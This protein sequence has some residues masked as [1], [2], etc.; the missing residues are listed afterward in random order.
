[1]AH[2]R[3]APHGNRRPPR[4]RPEAHVVQPP[5]IAAPI[6]EQA[7]IGTPVWI[8]TA[9]QRREQHARTIGARQ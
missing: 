9:Q 7:V 3:E 8:S 6:W 5:P 2:P 1:M 4:S